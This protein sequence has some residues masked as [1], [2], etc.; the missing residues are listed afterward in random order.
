MPS[1]D[2]YAQQS[3]KLGRAGIDALTKSEVAALHAEL[4]AWQEAGWRTWLV[5]HNQAI[6]EYLS[7]TPSARQKCPTWQAVKSKL[8]LAHY[9]ECERAA[10][11]L[12]LAADPA[13]QSGGPYRDMVVTAS[14]GYWALDGF[15]PELWPFSG[16]SP[17]CD[18]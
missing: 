17:F 16:E 5:V 8:A 3:R 15:E 13:L 18:A 11:V 2:K 9:Y 7:A 4:A 6:S 10:M 14:N 12:M 1:I